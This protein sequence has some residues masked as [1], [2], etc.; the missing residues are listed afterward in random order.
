MFHDDWFIYI[1]L[2]IIIVNMIF[3]VFVRK[4]F[5]LTVFD[6]KYQQQ[7]KTVVLF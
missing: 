4:L 1:I 3:S 5:D 6:P 7:Q 2:P